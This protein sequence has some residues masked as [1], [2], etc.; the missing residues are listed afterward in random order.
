GLRKALGFADKSTQKYAKR[1]VMGLTRI[2]WIA[3]AVGAIAA[4]AIGLVGGALAALPALGAGGVAAISLVALG[5]D[6]INEAAQA[7]AREFNNLKDSISQIYADGLVSQFEQLGGGIAKTQPAMEDVARAT[8]VAGQG[9]TKGVS[10][11]L[12]V[13]LIIK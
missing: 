13:E 1:T 12:G 3:T 10:F 5:M 4:P 8:R 2:G 7:A 9:V 11:G 6:G